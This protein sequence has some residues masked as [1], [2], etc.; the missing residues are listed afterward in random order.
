MKK[1]SVI[2]FS[3]SLFFGGFLTPEVRAQ[4]D[5]Q[6]TQYMYNPLTINPA[7]AG[8]RGTLSLVGLHRTQW[9]G[10]DGA[11]TTFSISGHSPVGSSERVG[12]GFNLVRD[13]IF[14]TNETHIDIDFSYTI[15]TSDIGKL[16]FGL[17]GGAHL[18]DIN[19]SQ[20]S[21]FQDGDIYATNQAD[22]D[23]R[24]SPQVGVGLFYYTDRAY[25]GL[26]VPNLLQTEHFEASDN[27]NLTTG[28]QTFLAEERMHFY[29]TAGKVFPLGSDLKFKPAT[30]VKV[31]QGAPLQV[32][33]TAN[34][35]LYEKLTLGAA[36]RWSAA[37]SG[38]IGFQ[39]SD[40][41]MLGFAYDSETTELR[42]YNDGSY[43]FF[44][45]FEVFKNTKKI[46]SPRF[47]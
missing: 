16:S 4:Q 19:Y 35:L 28:N 8:T 32:D 1:V 45:R 34:F 26:S 20:A 39:L 17:K 12:L 10:L 30:M 25:L 11:P 2:L 21:A 47:F 46:L 42:Q 9:A 3:L 24:F 29:L 38:L 27:S 36:Y 14:I 6:Y 37:I 43:E 15:P 5:P 18:L 44:L 7:Y 41:I 33:L 31:V 13:E 22:I 40:N 23:N